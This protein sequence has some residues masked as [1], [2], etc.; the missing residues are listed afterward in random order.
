MLSIST[1]Y[2]QKSEIQNLHFNDELRHLE[3][4]LILQKK[5]VENSV[6]NFAIYSLFKRQRRPHNFLQS[7]LENATA[8][9]SE[10]FVESLSQFSILFFD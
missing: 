3:Q 5:I 4:V 9:F 6:S 8:E 1:R 10:K 2:V 7:F